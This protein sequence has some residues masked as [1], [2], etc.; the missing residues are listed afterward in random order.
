MG[1]LKTSPVYLCDKKHKEGETRKTRDVGC[2]S[3]YFLKYGL[4]TTRESQECSL[5][6]IRDLFRLFP[7]PRSLLSSVCF[8]TCSFD[9]PVSTSTLWLLPVRCRRCR[10][11]ASVASNPGQTDSP[12]QKDESWCEIKSYFNCFP[13]LWEARLWGVRE[14]CCILVNFRPR[15]HVCR[16]GNISPQFNVRRWLNLKFCCK[17]FSVQTSW[18]THAGHSR[19]NKH[20]FLQQSALLTRLA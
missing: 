8:S 3:S 16:W 15:N 18:Q 6:R 13:G 2:F 7:Q 10:V 12:G 19:L 14:I 4:A 5:K 9:S 11:G 17:Q 1:C 20:A